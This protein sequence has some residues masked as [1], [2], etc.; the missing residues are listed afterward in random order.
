MWTV[1]SDVFFFQS[2][3]L[4]FFPEMVLC[5][6]LNDPRVP[7]RQWIII[8]HHKFMTENGTDLSTDW[9]SQMLIF[10][11][12]SLYPSSS[13]MCFLACGLSLLFYE[14]LVLLTVDL[15]KVACPHTVTKGMGT[16]D[17]FSFRW[18]ADAPSTQGIC[19]PGHSVLC[20]PFLLPAMGLISPGLLQPLSFPTT[21]CFLL[22]GALLPLI[23]E[24]IWRSGWPEQTPPLEQH[25][26]GV[27]DPG[28]QETCSCPR[29]LH[30]N[31]T[32]MT[33]F[34]AKRITCKPRHPSKRI[35]S[36]LV[37]H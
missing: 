14:I 23:T 37:P 36:G 10:M 29:I 26:S 4:W 12:P 27:G 19:P 21:W 22:F 5:I 30:R 33:L 2:G 18:W 7:C 31:Q 16:R 24:G 28:C 17:R 8:C 34:P 11:P 20:G 9:K 32:T 15:R 6:T 13:V 25:Y 35:I 1:S 3:T